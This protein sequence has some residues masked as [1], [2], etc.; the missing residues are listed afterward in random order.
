ML[1]RF[2]EDG[3][4]RGSNCGEKSRDDVEICTGREDDEKG[5]VRRSYR[6][7]KKIYGS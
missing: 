1:G 7:L 2:K 4:C 6:M 5:R 3:T